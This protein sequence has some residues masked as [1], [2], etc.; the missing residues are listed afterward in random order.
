MALA[1]PKNKLQ[2]FEKL[3]KARGVETTVIGKFTN[4]GKC[5]VKY[6]GKNVL[7]LEMEFLHDGRPQ[8]QLITRNSPTHKL[9]AQRQLPLTSNLLTLLSSLNITSTEFVSRQYD[10]EVQ[11]GSVIKPLQGRGLVNSDAS[12]IRPVLNSKKGAVLSYGLNPLLSEIDSYHMAATAIDSAIR[13]AVAA[14]ANIDYLALLDNFCWCSP[15]DPKRLYQLKQAA[16]ACYDFAT[17]YGTP[18]ISGKDSMYNDFKGFTSD[19][20]TT[21]I[22]IPPT[23][24]ITTVGVIPDVEK[25]ISIDVK[26]A[27]DLLY[28]LG[29]DDFKINAAKNLKL[30]RAIFQAN[31]QNL[32]ASA[33]SINFGGLG[34]ALAKS[35]MA[36]GLGAEVAT[37]FDLFSENQGRILISVDPKKASDFEKLME[38]NT[39]SKIGIV[40]KKPAMLIKDEKGKQINNIRIDQLLKSYKSTFKN[41]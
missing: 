6:S 24:L 12:V 7:D 32:I 15:E 2:K 19:G 9:P 16:K 40:T 29:A 4:S 41:Y 8:K 26:M 25:S 35:L 11:A 5:V 30:Y 13:A 10:H 1:V 37:N 3:M 22:S 27:G 23:L 33:I 28:V 21:K 14:G 18:F 36:G 38:G 34:V 17:A 39:I 20:K 31:Q